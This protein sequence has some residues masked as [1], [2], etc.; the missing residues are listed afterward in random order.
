MNRVYKNNKKNKKDIF[1]IAVTIFLLV[2]LSLIVVPKDV[3]DATDTRDYTDTAKFFAGEYSAKQRA[4]HPIL[5]GLIHA[6]FV[7]LFHNYIP[8]KLSSIF[9][10]SLLIIS[11]YFISNKN[12]KTLWLFLTAPIIWYM[13]VWIS[14]LPL[15]SLLFLWAYYFID[16]FDIQEKIRYLIYS[17]LLLGLA[18][19]FWT[20]ALYIS[21][22]FLFSFLYNKKFYNFLILSVF[23][24]IGFSPIL[25][26]DQILFGLPFYSLFKHMS[27]GIV[28]FLYGGI[29][30]QYEG[31][32]LRIIFTLLFVPFYFYLFFK[33]EN[34]LKY[35]KTIIFLTL[36]ILFILTTSQ[37]RLL[38]PITPIIIL[39]FGKIMNQKQFRIQI[40]MFLIL[41]LIAINPYLIQTKYQINGN[42]FGSFLSNL[43]NLT[44][45][46]FSS[47]LI[48]QDL[49]E[50]AKEYP[51]ETFVVGNHREDYRELAHLYWGKEIEEFVSIEDY[52]LFLKNESTIISKKL[53][54][55][56]RINDRREIWIEIGLDKNSNDKTDYDSINYAL[57]FDE[58]F[59]IK[60]FKLIK[61]YNV[62]YL[63]QKE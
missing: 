4:A 30:G 63:L 12:K 62:L 13:S 39:L 27:S 50:I 24:F 9:W 34:F 41:A 8:L 14:P 35:K 22:I 38:L 56:S 53:S 42:E 54:S 57:S 60:N 43:P 55:N 17:G 61:K 31:T 46:E 32:F 11:L 23:I 7:K 49:N 44:F 59:D 3:F 26:L 5:Y 19:A 48:Q 40:I 15:V 2:L 51:N 47:S 18:S 25:I 21:F 33:K 6:P 20:T 10:L 16:K 58:N 45:S 1:I 28:F 52:D 29:Y 37:I 36:F